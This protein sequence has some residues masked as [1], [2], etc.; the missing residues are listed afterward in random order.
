[1]QFVEDSG[2]GKGVRGRGIASGTFDHHQK[3][4]SAPI[5]MLDK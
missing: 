3:P 2:L 1:M 4:L 5:N